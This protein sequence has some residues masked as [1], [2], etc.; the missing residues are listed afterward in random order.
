MINGQKKKGLGLATHLGYPT[1]NLLL[2]KKFPCGFYDAD[3]DYGKVIMIVDHTN[4]F[5]ECHFKE[6][7]KNID[8]CMRFKFYNLT[9]IKDDGSGILGTYM[10]GCNR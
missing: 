1:I 2:N 6:Y 3:S 8:K 5:A 10:R 4:K 7:T 9:E